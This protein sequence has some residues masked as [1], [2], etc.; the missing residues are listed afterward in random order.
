[1]GVG[2]W[3]I[4]GWWERNSLDEESYRYSINTFPVVVR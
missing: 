2:G 4:R 1:M 3:E